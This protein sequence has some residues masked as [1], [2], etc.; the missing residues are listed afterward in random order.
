MLILSVKRRLTLALQVSFI[1]SSTDQLE[2]DYNNE[3]FLVQSAV[4][5]KRSGG[6]RRRELIAKLRN[7][8]M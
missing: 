2:L 1:L 5:W 3:A 7:G 8:E 4:F 6:E